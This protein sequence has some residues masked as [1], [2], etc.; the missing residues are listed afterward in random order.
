MATFNSR[1]RK[2]RRWGF[3]GNAA[4]RLNRDD[5]ADLELSIA[6]QL[7]RRT[8]L[9]VGKGRQPVATTTRRK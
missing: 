3:Q 2:T 5:S 6:H 7:T 9:V 4:G 1:P 8:Q